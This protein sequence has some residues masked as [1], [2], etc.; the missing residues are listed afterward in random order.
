MKKKKKT[1]KNLS[2]SSFHYIS[3]VIF[4]KEKV[5]F[6]LFF[7]K[8]YQPSVKNFVHIKSIYRNLAA[9]ECYVPQNLNL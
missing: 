7:F 1:T 8:T 5:I 3:K 4:Y 6:N 2:L 9:S